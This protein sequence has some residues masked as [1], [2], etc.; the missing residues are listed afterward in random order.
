MLT[1][2]T[3]YNPVG[4]RQDCTIS[5]PG[6]A[7]VSGICPDFVVDVSDESAVFEEA[8][9]S[10]LPCHSF[11]SSLGRSVSYFGICSGSFYIVLLR[12]LH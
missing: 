11:D 12:L 8:R 9:A 5:K 4:S 6:I 10:P 3:V 1:T 7:A 2:T